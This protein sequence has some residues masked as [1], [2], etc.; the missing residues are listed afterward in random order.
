MAGAERQ[1]GK[2]MRKKSRMAALLLAVLL[3]EASGAAFRMPVQAAGWEADVIIEEVTE[4]AGSG[5]A[6]GAPDSLQTEQLPEQRQEVSGEGTDTAAG[7]SFVLEVETLAQDGTVY[8]AEPMQAENETSQTGTEAPDGGF[9]ETETPETEPESPGSAQTELPET[10]PESPGSAETELP[11][12]E[13]E[14]PG[15]TET[16]PPTHVEKVYLGIDNRHL[17]DGMAQ[18]FADGYQPEVKDGAVHLT[19]P[20]TAS[21]ALK[22]DCLTVALVFEEK[23]NAPFVFRNNQKEVVRKHY[24]QV[25][26]RMTEVMDRAAGNIPEGGA[27]AGN[28]GASDTGNTGNTGNTDAEETDVYLYTCRIPLK[29]G[30]A[31]GQYSVTVKAWGYT[32]QMEQVTLE[33]QV[34]IQI[35]E[36]PVQGEKEAAGGMSAGGSG[37]G[38]G[39]GSAGGGAE[40]AEE[41]IRQPKMLLETCSL[42]GRSLEAGSAETLAVSFKN[43][44]NTQAMYNLKIVASVESESFLLAKN[45]WY[46]SKVEPGEEITLDG[47]VR[48]GA[49]AAAGNVPLSFDFEYEDKEGTAASGRETLT[50]SVIQ[51]VTMELEAADIP[52]EV[53]ASDTLELSVKALNL[54]RTGVYNVRME[55]SGDGMFPLGEIFLGNMEAGTEGSAAM[56]VYVGTRTMEAIGQETGTTDQEKYGP[57]SGTILLRYEDAFGETHE[58]SKPYQTEIKQ[59]QL[60]SLKV[61][62]EEPEANSWWISVFVAV[63]AGL[64]L[65]ILLLLQ[66]LHRKNVLLDEAKRSLS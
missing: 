42:S 19:V 47:S 16:E 23:E 18:T 58:L 43:H 60:L 62:D 2:Q 9:S 52:A 56:R 57:V 39:G 32:E 10:E 27:D 41:I 61:E 15:G 49:D 11:E 45:S 37:Y 46:V 50:L 35:P 38:G 65:L 53:Y 8:G 6:L 48:I 21:G 66:R 5:S 13:P 20:F 44:S 24:L 51:P 59:A 4:A 1:R 14:S 33:C 28:A 31:P 7:D 26:G 63:I 64:G 22:G 17:Y 40:Q 3:A 12:T 55:L 29:E 54:S 30:A 34:F 36:E 25:D